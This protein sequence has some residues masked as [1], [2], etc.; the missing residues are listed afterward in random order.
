MNTLKIP[1]CLFLDEKNVVTRELHTCDASEETFAAA[2]YIRNT[3]SN[4]NNL[5]KILKAKTKLFT[6]YNV[7]FTPIM[8]PK[9]VMRVSGRINK[10]NLPYLN[11]HPMILPSDHPLTKRESVPS[12]TATFKYGFSTITYTTTLLDHPRASNG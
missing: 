5:I 9:Q 7:S 12:K 1:R 4:E 2:V 11:R 3:Y 8:D 10:A 6:L